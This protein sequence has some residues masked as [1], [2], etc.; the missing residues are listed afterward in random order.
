ML[1]GEGVVAVVVGVV[2]VRAVLG[3]V[4]VTVLVGVAL[5]FE[6]VLDFAGVVPV[7]G[8]NAAYST[9]PTGAE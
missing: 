9:V 6:L 5:G 1:P 4:T 7:P 3:T 8:W 2:A